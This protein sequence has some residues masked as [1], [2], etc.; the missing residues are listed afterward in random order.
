MLSSVPVMYSASSDASST[1]AAA[2]SSGRVHALLLA[3]VD[4]GR[5]EPDMVAALWT[6]GE[7][8]FDAEP[9]VSG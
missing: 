2:T 7:H 3:E 9:L 5:V 1:A 8:D 4:M 6:H